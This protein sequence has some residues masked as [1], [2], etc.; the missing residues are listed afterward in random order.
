MSEYNRPQFEEIAFEHMD[1]LFSKALKMTRN[2]TDAEDLIQET[3]FRAYKS[4]QQFKPGTNF[5]AWIFTILTNNYI[6]DYRKKMRTP[7]HVELDQVQHRVSY[8][9][10]ERKKSNPDEESN[11]DTYE[12]WFDDHVV[13]ALSSLSHDFRQVVLLADVQGLPYKEIA[14]KIGTP[15]GTVMSRIFRGRKTLRR[16]LASY[17]EQYGIN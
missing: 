8:Q 2:P 17:A 3:Y 6:N 10:A 9:E 1:A 13:K 16:K 5:R 4:Y 15:V 14:K 11:P 7:H 12:D